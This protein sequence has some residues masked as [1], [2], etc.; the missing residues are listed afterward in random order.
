MS[1]V[2][3]APSAPGTTESTGRTVLVRVALLLPVL[4]ALQLVLGAHRADAAPRAVSPAAAVAT[5]VVTPPTIPPLSLSPIP[6]VGTVADQTN[7]TGSASVNIDLGNTVNKP[8]QSVLI[9]IL[10]TLISVAP[11][12]LI[13]TTS[14]TR[15]SIVLSLT[16][17]ALGLQSIPP[18]QVI[19]GL[20][21][22]L[23]LF[24]MKPTLTKVNDDAL[25]PLLKG[26]ITQTQA[27][28][29]AAAPMKSFMLK[30]VG[31]SELSMF[32]KASGEARPKKAADVPLPTLIP[33][34]ILSE[35]KTAFI[36]GFVIFIPFLVIDMVVSSSLMSMGMMM[37]PPVMISLPF[38]MLL[39]VLVDGWALVIKSLV[40]S[41]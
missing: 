21:L 39:F 30:Q 5:Q 22:F 24:V 9:I 17:N 1:L 32:Q 15:I 7:G 18:N 4:F 37:L 34:F 14:F 28:D 6:A 23:S 19:V 38:K 16:R 13:L 26:Q 2:P 41:F 29:R 11:A 33:A 31:K 35:L 40:D 27:F 10:L 3:A 20:A 12:I 25:Q 36:I 8:N